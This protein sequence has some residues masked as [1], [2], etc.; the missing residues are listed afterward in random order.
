[1]HTYDLNIQKEVAQEPQLKIIL[2]KEW[3]W[4][5][6]E[7]YFIWEI[8]Y[9]HTMESCVHVCVDLCVLH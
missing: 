1:M 4:E 5:K 3:I 2:N 7:I 8:V 9:T 6:S